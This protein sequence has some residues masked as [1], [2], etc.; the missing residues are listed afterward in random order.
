MKFK[1]SV[2]IIL[3]TIIVL[4]LFA[5]LAGC[6]SNPGK[7]EM[8][9]SYNTPQQWANWAAVLQE[10]TKETG[11][12]APNDNKNSGQTI[13]ALTAEKNNPVADVAY[14]GIVFGINAVKDDLVE[15]YK[16][17]HFDEIPVDLKD[18]DGKWMTVHYG[19]I[20]FLVNTQALGDVPVPQSWEDLLKPEYNGKVGFLDPASAAVGY[21]VVTAANI[22]MGGSLDNWQPALD[23]FN[24]LALNNV[25][26][27]MQTATAKVLKGEI[28]ILIDAD[29]N[30]YAMKYNDKGPIEVVIPKEGSLKVPY[31]MSLVKNSPNSENGK[32]LL[33]FAL[34]DDGQKLFAEGYVMPIRGGALT[35]DV[36][37]K[38]LPEADYARVKDVDYKKMNEQQG[39]FIEL[40]K[41]EYINQ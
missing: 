38:F 15:G 30:G 25:V 10:F 6:S 2:S 33:D 36:K 3:L 22:A 16:P 23:Y 19:A 21:S 39:A 8:V 32:K 7:E 4:G 37:A 12:K 9:I 27:P 5:G 34:S 29:F 24:K 31:V 35:S 13:T 20:A 17:P 11:I 18:P 41:K 14:Y 40:W 28:P 1:N 26:N